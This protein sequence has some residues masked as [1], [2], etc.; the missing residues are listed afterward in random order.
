MIDFIPYPDYIPVEKEKSFRWD[1]KEMSS[2]T[3]FFAYMPFQNSMQT[4]EM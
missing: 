4:N 3:F 1:S 2:T